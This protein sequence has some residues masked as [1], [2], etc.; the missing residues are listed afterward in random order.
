MRREQALPIFPR[1]DMKRTDI[2]ILATIMAAAGLTIML[3][4]CET[5]QLTDPHSALSRSRHAATVNDKWELLAKD[6]LHDMDGLRDP[7]NPATQLVQEPR[8]V[9]SGLTPDPAGNK[10]NW[11]KALVNGAINPRRAK[12]APANGVVAE[13]LVM[14][15]DILL[16]V[17]GSMPRVRFPHRAHTMWLACA[18][19]HPAIFVPQKGAN[20][21][22]MEKILMGQQCGI[23]HGAVAFPP[24]DCVRCHS[25]PQISPL[26]IRPTAD[27]GGHP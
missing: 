1:D 25:V 13:E 3:A 4:A 9:L 24:T 11:V 19:C 15:M 26:L 23:C 7:A 2:R 21:I 18:N 10:V 20:A 5:I 17:N 16:N 12:V 8:D 22:R 27:A 6:G 14:D